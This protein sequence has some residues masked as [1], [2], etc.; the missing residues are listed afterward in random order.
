MRRLT[1][2]TS[3]DGD[4]IVSVTTQGPYWASIDPISERQRHE[5]QVINT[6]CTHFVRC[7]ARLDIRETDEISFK[8]RNFEILTIVDLHEY[9]RDK[10]ITTKEIRPK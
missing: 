4:A 5:Y 9:E 3:A 6:E 2:T 10:L 8:G 7:D 1:R